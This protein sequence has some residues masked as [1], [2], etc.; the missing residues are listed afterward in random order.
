MPDLHERYLTDQNGTRVGVVLDITQ[1]EQM[2][3]DLEELESIRAFDAAQESGDEAIPF[4]Q[5]INEIARQR[6]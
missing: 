5:E 1:Y 6:K 2:L 4:E 3:A